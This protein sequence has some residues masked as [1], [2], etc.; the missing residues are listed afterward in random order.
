MHL[1]YKKKTNPHMNTAVMTPHIIG[2]IVS[3]NSWSRC[4]DGAIEI[5]FSDDSR[6]WRCFSSIPING[7]FVNRGIDGGGSK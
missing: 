4:M 7:W 1:R 5:E 2:L 6:C 3:T